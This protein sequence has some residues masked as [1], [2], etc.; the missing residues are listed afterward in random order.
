MKVSKEEKRTGHVARMRETRNTYRILALKCVGNG[1]LYKP[2]RRREDITWIGRKGIFGHFAYGR[3]PPKA[4]NFLSKQRATIGLS[5][6]TLLHG[7][8]YILRISGDRCAR[9][10]SKLADNIWLW[11]GTGRCRISCNVTARHINGCPAKFTIGQI[12]LV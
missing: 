5:K 11:E 9:Y 6:R 3:F 8:S 2:R 10:L 12:R 7:F 4:G 1:P